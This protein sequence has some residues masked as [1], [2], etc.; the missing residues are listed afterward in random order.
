M[1]SSLI[2]TPAVSFVRDTKPHCQ[3][4]RHNW[5]VPVVAVSLGI[6]WY[7][8]ALYPAAFGSKADLLYQQRLPFDFR[9]KLFI[10]AH[11]GFVVM[12]TGLNVLRHFTHRDLVV[13]E[14]AN[15][16]SLAD[17]A[18]HLEAATRRN[19]ISTGGLQRAS[20]TASGDA[21]SWLRRTAS[22]A[23]DTAELL[24][25]KHEA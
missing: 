8:E 7:I 14:H 18:E 20:A 9:L 6:L 25:A 13:T 23:S 5:L 22:T 15:A 3:N 10:A 24:A 12:V 11:I 16:Q 4:L 2:L 21:T 19:S 17:A 1:G